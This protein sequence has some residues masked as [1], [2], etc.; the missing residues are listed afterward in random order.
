LYKDNNIGLI[1]YQNFISPGA[2]NDNTFLEIVSALK[3]QTVQ[4]EVQ[5]ICTAS[6]KLRDVIVCIEKHDPLCSR[7]L[8]GKSWVSNICKIPLISSYC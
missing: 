1:F 3:L 4:K 8:S 6:G 2:T 7:R 5:L